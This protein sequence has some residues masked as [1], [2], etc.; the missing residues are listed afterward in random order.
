MIL[1]EPLFLYVSDNYFTSFG[2]T[3]AMGKHLIIF[4][5]ILLS[6]LK[7]SYLVL[8][9]VETG[10]S[11]ENRI[12]LA[13]TDEQDLREHDQQHGD[14]ANILETD[15]LLASQLS[16][17]DH[18]LNILRSLQ[19]RNP[20][21]YIRLGRQP[22][23]FIRLG[24]SDKGYIRFGRSGGGSD[25]SGSDTP[26]KDS[27][28]MRFGRN[29]NADDIVASDVTANAGTGNTDDNM[30]FGR[31]GDKFIRFGRSQQN[32]NK[33]G[34]KVPRSESFIRFGRNA[35][36]NGFIRL[37]KKNA[38]GK[39]V[40]FSKLPL[41]IDLFL[42]NA[43]LQQHQKQLDLDQSIIDNAVINDFIQKQEQLGHS[44]DYDLPPKYFPNKK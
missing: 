15:Y 11:L 10:P 28:L 38:V 39:S 20:Q 26:N 33:I 37:G 27:Y 29:I 21:S 32:L 40:D 7:S 17:P 41:P 14:S 19:K 5:I 36:D 43:A 35:N 18:M 8:A 2:L 9:T 1:M 16:E 13:S 12:S 30:R 3:S 44:L 23:S 6:V 24:R 34:E 31:R 42:K 22:N 25:S 4:E